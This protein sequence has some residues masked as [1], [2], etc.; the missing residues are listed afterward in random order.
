M[1]IKF[2]QEQIVRIMKEAI[3]VPSPV[4]YYDKIHEWL[5][6]QAKLLGYDITF[7]RKRT[8]YITI[9]GE[10]TNK[11]VCVGAHVDTLG[12]MVRH[13]NA[14][15]TLL[16]R[17]LGGV[18]FHSLDGESVTIH[19]RDGRT[20]TGM[21]VCQSHSVHVFDDARTLPRDENTMYVV[22]DEF[23]KSAEDVY[24]LGIE[25]GD[26]ISFDPHFVYTKEG[27]IRSRFIDNKACVAISFA[28]LDYLKKHHLKPKYTTH[29]AFPIY[30]E[31]SHGGAY[32]PEGIEEY[33]ALDIGLIGPDY[34]GSEDKVSICA[35][36][37]FSPYDRNL[38]TSIIQYAKAADVNYC[39]DVFY[40]Y[41]T[42]ANA[43]IRAGNNLYAAAFGM[44][45]LCSHGV[46]RTHIKGVVETAKLTLAY[47]LDLKGKESLYETSTSNKR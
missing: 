9:E 10:D 26:V 1:E 40:R 22:L 38:V 20:Y 32:V 33:V 29:F 8:A 18:N 45:C 3:E 6:K 42:D 12:C 17:N 13:V 27:F 43:A 35:K 7:D 28:V 41:G 34:H 19:T 11:Q 16:M 46:E 31:I 23:V 44:G 5:K 47:V 36:D 4:G 2:D 21:I 39:V 24:A 30:E 25:H 15:G 14:D 37:N